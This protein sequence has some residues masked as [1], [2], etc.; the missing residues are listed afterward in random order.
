MST[1]K[2]KVSLTL[3][4]S[5]PVLGDSGSLPPPINPF[6]AN[7]ASGGGLDS[8]RMSTDPTA[9]APAPAPTLNLATKEQTSRAQSAPILGIA[10]PISAGLNAGAQVQPTANAESAI[11]QTATSALGGAASGALSGAAIG[12]A[13]GP[14]GAAGGAAIG[15][16]VSLVSGGVQA[17]LGLKDARA[18]NRANER[19]AAYIKK[20][21]EDERKY[22]RG[23]D[24]QRRG[25]NQEQARYNRR[26]SALASQ[27]KAMQSTMDILNQGIRDDENI[28]ALFVK[29]AR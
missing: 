1:K 24:A 10:A 19:Q 23:Q 5:D 2:K 15:G 28:R 26:Q 25:D 6:A 22:N 8:M 11:L 13:G 14:I 9:R 16:L 20:W 3:D 29:G 17:Y 21:N 12:A 27:W 7:P 18:K 4:T